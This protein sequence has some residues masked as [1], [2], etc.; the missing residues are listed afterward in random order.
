MTVK[1]SVSDLLSVTFALAVLCLLVKWVVAPSEFF[2]LAGVPPIFYPSIPVVGF[3]LSLV[4]LFC[5][6]MWVFSVGMVLTEDRRPFS[7]LVF[8]SVQLLVIFAD[9]TVWDVGLRFCIAVLISAVAMIVEVKLRLLA[10]RHI[11]A[12]WIALAV[13]IAWYIAIVC[14][15]VSASI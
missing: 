13:S 14:I 3:G 6:P 9:V 4:P 1:F 5:M 15:V 2:S 11:L 7:S 12:S 8:F 10:P